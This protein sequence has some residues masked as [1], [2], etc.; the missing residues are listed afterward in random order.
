MK[1]ISV[2]YGLRLTIALLL[3]F[4]LA[5]LTG[6]IHHPGLRVFNGV[7]H[8]GLVYLAIRRYRLLYPRDWNYATGVGVGVAAG[9]IGTVLFA[10]GVGLFLALRPDVLAEIAANTR[11]A[12]Y[13]N[14]VTAAA[15]LTVEGFAVT[16]FASYFSMRIV[17]AAVKPGRKPKR[18][19]REREGWP[20][21]QRLFVG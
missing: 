9:M 13:L 20:A 5:Q 7:F 3:L 12:T 21:W 6:L 14:P 2:R 15:V 19:R 4:S 16:V 18:L 10:A 17:D 1:S 11:L 8:L